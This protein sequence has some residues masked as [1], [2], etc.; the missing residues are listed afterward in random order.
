MNEPLLPGD[1]TNKKY[2]RARFVDTELMQGVGAGIGRVD[3]GI[4]AVVH[5]VDFAW[6]DLAVVGENVRSH[7]LAH[8][9][10]GIAVL[11]TRG[12]NPR[13]DLVAAAELFALP[14]PQRFE[15]VRGEYVGHVVEQG[16]DVSG[17]VRVPGV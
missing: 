17:E 13:R 7:A 2:V 1:A 3:R 11:V 9:D 8:R 6:I 15:G 16:R 14:W 12:L 5:N 10:D 4:D